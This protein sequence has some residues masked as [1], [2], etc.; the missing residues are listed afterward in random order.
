MAVGP[1]SRSGSREHQ[2][3]PGA[4]L[5]LGE[6]D[7]ESANQGNQ[8][9]P[10]QT[11]SATGWPAMRGLP[12]LCHQEP[13]ALSLGSPSAGVKGRLPL[14]FLL[15]LQPLCCMGRRRGRKMEGE[16]KKEEKRRGRG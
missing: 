6:A 15:D 7:G 4:L 9:S 13:P 16:T 5:Q 10:V 8:G 14:H 11:N 3:G 1:P 12:G 2:R